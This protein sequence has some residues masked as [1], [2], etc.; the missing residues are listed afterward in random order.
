MKEGQMWV[1]Y[2][3]TDFSEQNIIL[4]KYKRGGDGGAMARS[5]Q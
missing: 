3:G 4:P 5:D 2:I 1:T